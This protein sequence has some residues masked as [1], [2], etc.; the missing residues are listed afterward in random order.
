MLLK[1]SAE[2][3]QIS[4]G[5][6]SHPSRSLDE[7]LDDESCHLVTQAIQEGRDFAECGAFSLLVLEVPPD[8]RNG[9]DGRFKHHP[10]EGVEEPRA[11]ADTHGA[12]GV[13]VIAPFQHGEELPRSALINPVLVCNLESHFHRRGAVVGIEDLG[14]ASESGCLQKA[15][16]KQYG[17]LM[18][19]SGE[20]H[21]VELQD[22]IGHCLCKLRTAVTM[23]I[24]PPGRDHV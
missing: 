8:E 2:F 21:M 23:E 5:V 15:L 17:G 11:P 4:G 13:A 16:G 20:L 9:K 14:L 22:L 19:C 6:E 7:R 18:G 24:H 3:A 10:R 1:E 12:H